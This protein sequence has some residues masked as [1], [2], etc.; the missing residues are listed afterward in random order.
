[1]APHGFCRDT[2]DV[3]DAQ[4]KPLYWDGN[5]LSRTGS[6]ERITPIVSNG[7]WPVRD[8]NPAAAAALT[9]P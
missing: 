8:V 5:H 2:C 1:M 9:Q 7:L 3:V 4:G 6:L